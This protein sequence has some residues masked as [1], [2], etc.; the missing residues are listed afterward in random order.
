MALKYVIDK[1]EDV[2]APVRSHYTKAD[3][4]KFR[5]AVDGEHPDAAKVKEMRTTNIDLMRER[6]ELKTKVADLD[7]AKPH[8]R[9]TELET[10]LA[11]EKAAR[12]AAQA[13]ADESLLSSTV[14]AKFF[15]KGGR[16]SAA[17]FIVSKAKDALT[18][19][20]GVIVG[21]VFDPNKPGVKLDVD[22]FIAMQVRE[23][24]FAFKPSSGG[25]ADPKRGG[26]T[27]G[28]RELVNPTA[29]ELGDPANA[30]AIRRGELK[31]VY[32]T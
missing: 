4:G 22:G 10:A 21:K 17:E 23:A 12:T 27:S 3:D 31:V 9:I 26:G 7:R 2:E 13:A 16:T 1:L 24:D 11:A 30:S 14:T 25:G 8:E 15:A 28:A 18:I 29:A 5:L 32:T 19:E 20:N 6:D